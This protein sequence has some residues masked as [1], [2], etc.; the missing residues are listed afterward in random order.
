[1]SETTT[2]AIVVAQHGGPEV[3]QWREVEVGR[4]GPGQV[5]VRQRA[6]GLNYIDV[7]YRTG[8]YAPAALP[9]TPGQEAAAVV[10]EVGP[11][12]SELRPGDRVAYATR[13]QGAYAEARVLPAE[14]LVKLPDALD[15]ATA[16]ALMLKGMT[17]QYLLRQTRPVGPGDTILF[18]AAA[19]GVGLLACQWARHL[20][21]RVI[22]TV[23]S[24]DKAALA[25]AHGCDEVIVYT[26]EDFVARVKELTGGAG[27]PV[28][29]DGVGQ[30]TFD[31]S[32]QCLRPRGMLVLFGQ[33]SGK[34]PPFDPGRL[35]ALGSL[36]LT[37]PTLF[38]Y[39][40]TRADLE[41]CAQDVFAAV[42]SGAVRVPIGQRF[43]LHEAARAHAALEAR[44]TTGATV[45]TVG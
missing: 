35:A 4:P 38:H 45:L 26:R 27:V 39:T 12:V 37:R 29:Y 21:A 5:R 17:A 30:A 11:G 6:I 13:G 2:R 22:G 8:V 42:A 44:A 19:G 31:G 28:V 24:D 9:F 36:Y 32:L 16:A 41:A 7:Y 33:A 20:G 40:A 34:V 18:H 25:R 10:E 43:P 23:G 1:M 14:V 3:L 15:D